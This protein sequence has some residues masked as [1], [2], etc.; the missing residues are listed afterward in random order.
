MSV[1]SADVAASAPLLSA[2]RLQA[3][4]DI[5]DALSA[6][7]PV[8]VLFHDKVPGESL[9]YAECIRQL[10]PG[11][12]GVTDV[13]RDFQV[14]ARDS[15][16]NGQQ[17]GCLSEDELAAVMHYT[18]EWSSGPPLYK[19][20]N[21]KCYNA[22]RN[23]IR[24]YVDFMWLLLSALG[25]IAPFHKDTV[26]RGV[27]KNLLR[28][29]CEGHEFT[30]H[31]FISCTTKLKVLEKPDFF[32][33]VGPRTFF[34]IR[35]SQKQA[36]EISKY[37]LVQEEEVLLP[38]GSRFQVTDSADMGGGLAF[39]YLTE[40]E[41]PFWIRDLSPKTEAS[42]KVAQETSSELLTPQQALAA[43]ASKAKS[44]TAPG[45]AAKVA[46]P[47]PAVR[48]AAAPVASPALAYAYA[49]PAAAA[50]AVPK[51][52][53]GAAAV[54]VAV[55]KSPGGA[56]AAKVASPKPAVRPAAAPVASPALAYAY[57]GPAAAA[58]AVPKTPSGAVS[59][60]QA[61]AH[62]AVPTT[63]SI[64]AAAPVASPALAYPGP[65]A[66]AAAVPKTPSGAA[67]G[68]LTLGSISLEEA[69]AAADKCTDIHRAIKEGNQEA[70]QGHIHRGNA[71]KKILGGGH[72]PLHRAAEEG[73]ASI[74]LQL[75]E[76]RAPLEESRDRRKTPLHD[77]A[78][79]GHEDVVLVLLEARASFRATDSFGTTPLHYA[80][81]AG[82]Q[83][84]VRQLLNAGAD[85]MARDRD[86]QIPEIPPEIEALGL[87]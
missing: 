25:R 85:R 77:A 49:G 34:Q 64:A 26:Y 4:L 46:S 62:A 21:S 12:A 6:K 31:G 22:D 27:K 17:D 35:L 82:K 69:A 10:A 24:P 38:P 42:S 83:A 57:A 43:W 67:T 72:T 28:E 45:A 68:S 55:P 9:G 5:P 50:A 37:S 40:L 32:G 3:G 84:V 29:Y 63:P 20:M 13:A 33:K 73:H 23:L 11:L 54:A 60:L 71:R 65:A 52:P 8:K 30:W 66:A 74:V 16:R 53:G 51:T 59:C 39:V 75:I 70:V 81:R 78:Q 18:A 7:Q 1:L 47:K 80:A 76:A 61:A 58:A 41:S 86:G 14:M 79:W 87:A 36:R 15:I 2:S 19:D 56:A 48:P 44:P